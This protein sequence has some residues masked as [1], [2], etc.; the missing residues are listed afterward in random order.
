MVESNSNL[1]GL[2]AALA[3]PTRRGIVARL[4]NGPLTV[5]ELAEP[6]DMSL[7]AVSKHVAVLDRAGLVRR[8]RRGRYI[9]CALQ[10]GRLKLVSDWVGDYEQFWN[11]RLDELE[12]VIEEHRR[13]RS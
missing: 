10:P 12:I 7:A 11:D 3:D 13:S 6:I 2:F 8:S 9:E 4:A 5:G 1:D